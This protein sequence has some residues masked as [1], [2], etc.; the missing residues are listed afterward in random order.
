MK[1]ML[2]FCT[3]SCVFLHG[4]DQTGVSV[5]QQ[6]WSFVA[7]LVFSFVLI[8]LQEKIDIFCDVLCRAQGVKS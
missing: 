8:L 2:F 4:K 7:P 3:E 1:G 6:L 5:L